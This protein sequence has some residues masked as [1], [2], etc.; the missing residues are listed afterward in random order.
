MNQTKLASMAEYQP[1]NNHWKW[2]HEDTLWGPIGA[3]LFELFNFVIARRPVSGW[4]PILEK[5]ES[6]PPTPLWR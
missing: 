1:K 4:P 5:H 6:N 3:K 2:E